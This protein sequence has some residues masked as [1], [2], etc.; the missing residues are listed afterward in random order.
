LPRASN[1]GLPSAFPE[2]AGQRFTNLVVTTGT[3][4]RLGKS[5][6]AGLE[7]RCDGCGRLYVKAYSEL[8]ADRAGCKP[9][10]KSSGVPNWLLMRCR[11]A[12]KRCE[13]PHDEFYPDYGARGIKFLFVSPVAMGFYVMNALGLRKDLTL[14]RRDNSRHYEPGNLRWASQTEQANNRRPRRRGYKRRRSTTSSTP[15]LA[16]ASPPLA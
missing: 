11:S 9:C 5:Q 10:S 2:L 12:K 16:T 6:R 13:N 14:D 15:A 3:I 7:V 1:K 4:V 8:K